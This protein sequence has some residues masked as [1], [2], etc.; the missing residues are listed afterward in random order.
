MCIRDRHGAEY[1]GKNGSLHFG[2]FLTRMVYYWM[3]IKF[4]LYNSE[5]IYFLFYLII[6]VCAFSVTEV[7]YCMHLFDIIDRFQTLKSVVRAVTYNINQLVLTF[8]FGLILIYMNSIIAFY[9]FY[10]TFYMNDGENTCTTLFQCLVCTIHFGLRLSGGISDALIV[11]SYESDNRE[12]Y[13]VRFLYDLIFF[14][15]IRVVFLNIIFGIIV[16]TFAQL[17]DKKIATDSDMKNR[18]YICNIERYLFD[19]NADG[20]LVH[21]ERDHCLWNYL[22]FIYHLQAKNSTEYNGIESYVHDKLKN[23]DSAWFPLNKAMSLSDSLENNE[24]ITAFMKTYSK[25]MQQ[26]LQTINSLSL[27]HI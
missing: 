6:S 12:R 8:V 13:Y 9:F 15:F 14:A 22:Y 4:V 21:I 1:M 7:L 18:C 16:D 20:F 17:R 19:R 25:E 27:I 24:E 2:N 10:D 11:Q 3:N 5:L 26:K 23:D